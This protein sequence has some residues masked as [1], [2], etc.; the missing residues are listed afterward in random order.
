MGAINPATIYRKLT[1]TEAV[2]VDIV[3]AVLPSIVAAFCVIYVLK[4]RALSARTHLMILVLSVGSA[5]SSHFVAVLLYGFSEGSIEILTVCTHGS[6]PWS[7]SSPYP[8]KGS[9]R[10]LAEAHGRDL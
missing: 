4:R 3:G 5:A 1:L 2:E 8:S 6:S 9:R 10:G 7:C